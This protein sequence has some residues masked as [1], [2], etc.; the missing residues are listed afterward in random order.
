MSRTP[1]RRGFTLVELLVVIGIIAVLI[2]ILLPALSGA[3]RSAQAVKCAS[4]LRQIGN[5]FQLYA[6]EYKGYAPP[7]RAGNVSGNAGVAGGSYNLYGITYNAPQN[8]D[9]V[10]IREAAFW[11][12]FIGKYLTKAN[13]GSGN[14]TFVDQKTAQASVIWG[15]PNWEGY[16]VT[17]TSAAAYGGNGGAGLN[18]QYV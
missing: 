3:R 18:Q 4:A 17:D 7:W 8:V 16:R 5:A 9:G 12:D 14:V 13:G 10:S 15:C 11:Y 1:Q 6:I 2:G